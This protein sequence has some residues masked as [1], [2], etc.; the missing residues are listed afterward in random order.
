[1]VYPPPE[2]GAN[3]MLAIISAED[4]KAG[5]E[6]CLKKT[7]SPSGSHLGHYRTALTS[8]SICFVYA[9]LISIPFDCG[10]TLDR[11]TNA[12]LVMLEKNK[13]TPSLNKLRVIQLMEADSNMV[14]RI[15]F[16]KSLYIVGRRII[17]LYH[18]YNGALDQIYLQLM[19]S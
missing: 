5:F 4:Y 6:T 12:L 19:P 9:T 8:D 16:G 1:M 2:N 11:W 3:P 15:V 10:F 13:G 18:H 14:L 17:K 7:S